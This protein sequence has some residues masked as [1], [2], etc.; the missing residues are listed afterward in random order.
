MAPAFRSPPRLP[1][2]NRS[3]RHHANGTATVSLVLRDRPWS[4]V[5][6]DMIDGIV[7]VNP[8]SDA[9]MLRDDLWATIEHIDLVD[10]PTEPSA[11]LRRVA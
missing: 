3:I 11:P 2:R 9:E 10:S 1:G 7:A 5:V 6:A 8:D 4:S